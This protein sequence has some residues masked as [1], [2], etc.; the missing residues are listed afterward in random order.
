MLARRAGV[1]LHTSSSCATSKYKW[2][3]TVYYVR[4]ETNE[5]PLWKI[6]VTSSSMEERY[7]VADRRIIAEIDSWIY[8]TRE[9]AEAFESEVLKE[10]SADRYRGEP[11]L[12]SGGNSELF[13]RD[14]LEIDSQSDIHA[15][16][17]R[18]RLAEEALSRLELKKMKE[19]ICWANAILDN[20]VFSFDENPLRFTSE[21]ISILREMH[22]IR[23]VDKWPGAIR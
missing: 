19:N 5:R 9:H 14:V 3:T 8:E 21:E 11:V 22:Q 17:R 20:R 7:C 6:G 16:V 1:K 13:T 15:I 4:V 18:Q 23:Q 12:L 2:E 10:F